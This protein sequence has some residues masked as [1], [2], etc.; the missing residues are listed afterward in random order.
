MKNVHP[1]VTERRKVR[2]IGK[3]G[4]GNAICLFCGCAEPML[5]RPV[6]RRFLEEHHVVGWEHDNELTLALC[7]NCHALVTERLLQAGVSMK[8]ES[9]PLEFACLLCSALAVHFQ[10]LSEAFWRFAALFR[11]QGE[12]HE[13]QGE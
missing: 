2:R 13:R 12:G 5:L 4:S 6:T 1:L 10:M 8:R 3:L 11:A 9:D 7:F